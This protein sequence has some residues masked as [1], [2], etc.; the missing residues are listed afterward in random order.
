MRQFYRL[1]LSAIVTLAACKHVDNPAGP[2]ATPGGDVD[3]SPG[4]D[5]GPID[6]DPSLPDGIAAARAA[7][8]G[9][10][11]ALAIHHATVTYLKP[12]IGNPPNDPPGFMVQGAKLGPAIF[13]AVDPAT[14]APA[15]AVGDVVD[16]TITGKHSV[17]QQPRATAITGF[18]RSQTGTDVRALVQDLTGATDIVSALDSYDSELVD[19]TA[20]VVVDFSAGGVG[21]L[22]ATV[23]TAALVNTNFQIR[24]PADV[25]DAIDLVRTCEVAARSVPM[26]RFNAAAQLAIFKPSEMVVRDCPAPQITG[27]AAISSSAIRLTFSRHIAPGSVLANGSQFTADHGLAITGATVSGRTVTL[28]TSAQSAATAYGVT[29]AATVKDLQGSSLDGNTTSFTG[30]G[31]GSGA[32]LSKHTKLGIPS[33]SSAADPNSFLSVKSEYVVSYNGSRKVPNWVSWEL[34]STYLGSTDRQNDYRP[35][36]TFPASEPQAS[37]ADYSGSGYERGHMC[38]SADRTLSAAVNS[39]TFYLTN[40]VPQAPNN[41]E[42][43]WA[44]LEG[45]SRTLARAGKELFI[46]SGGTFSAGSNTVGNGMKVP[47]YTFKVIVVLD[48]PGQ[49]PADVTTSTRVI[50]VLMPNDNA[51]IPMNA[52][53]KDY[54]VSVDMIEAMTG[55]DFLSDVSP[56]VQAV[57]EARVDNQ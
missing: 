50:G 18:S 55:Y 56:A 51:L 13:V 34:N 43:A 23:S 46:I 10:G 49:G 19:L 57:V 20:D 3:A 5:A 54:R 53:W 44:V 9:D 47:D 1:A 11:L 4:I 35:D 15:P 6:S 17:G 38:P 33:P 25:V 26:S 7:G 12:A 2:D 21:F 16:F 39:Q 22:R 48:A 45:D 40:M 29:I 27:A 37:L 36:D 32:A 24:L 52:N 14:L 31:P 30:F 41:N 42:G 8:D 28:T